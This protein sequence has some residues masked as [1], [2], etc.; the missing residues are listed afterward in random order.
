MSL[1]GVAPGAVLEDID[2]IIP[3]VSDGAHVAE[4]ALNGVSLDQGVARDDARLPHGVALTTG[5]RGLV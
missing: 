2:V 3:V 1:H 5:E 4:L